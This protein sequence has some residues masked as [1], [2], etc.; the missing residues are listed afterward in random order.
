[1]FVQTAKQFVLPLFIQL[2]FLIE[3]KIDA[4]S[5][6]LLQQKQSFVCVGRGTERG[7]GSV[8]I[9]LTDEFKSI[10]NLRK[11]LHSEL[12][13]AIHARMTQTRPSFERMEAKPPFVA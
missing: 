1:M 6:I 4:T 2:D 11:Q 5:E 10:V 13:F 12:P 8:A 3:T 9:L 7:Y